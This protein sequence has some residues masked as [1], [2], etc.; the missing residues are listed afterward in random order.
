MVIIMAFSLVKYSAFLCAGLLTMVL[1]LFLTRPCSAGRC[2]CCWP[3]DANFGAV[4]WL[5]GLIR[6]SGSLFRFRC[7]TAGLELD[8]GDNKLLMR[9]EEDEPDELD[10]SERYEAEAMR[11]DLLAFSMMAAI[12]ASD[13]PRARL[14]EAN[15]EDKSSLWLAWA[16]FLGD[17]MDRSRASFEFIEGE[18]S[19]SVE[20]RLGLV[21]EGVRMRASMGDPCWAWF[22]K[23][24]HESRLALDLG[25]DEE[26]DELEGGVP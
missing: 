15:G 17:G 21:G 10:E 13:W 11:G 9:V 12:E 3:P 16:D 19:A 7:G 14:A 18:L 20:L 5:L 1:G 23:E 22:D 24:W 8:T 25:L 26:L 2:C 4:G 6:R